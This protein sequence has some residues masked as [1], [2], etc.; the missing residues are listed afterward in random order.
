MK[1]FLKIVKLYRGKNLYLTIDSRIQDIVYKTLQGL[2]SG[3]IVSRVATGEI[4]AIYS[5]PSYDPNIFVGE[6]DKK[7]FEKYSK[8]KDKPF[9]NRVIQGGYPPSSTYK[10]VVSLTALDQRGIDFGT[11]YLCLGKIYIGSQ[12]FTC[13]GIHLTQHFDSAISNSCNV[14]FYKLGLKIGPKTISKYSENYFNLG[15]KTGIDLL[16]EL[17]GRIPNQKWK[18]E[19]TGNF[20]WDGDTANTSIG[21]GF[22][23]VTIAQ[24]HLITTAIANDGKGY[25]LHLLRKYQSPDTS[26]T[27]KP[28]KTATIDFPFNIRNIKYIQKAMRQVVING[29]ARRIN[30]PNLSIAGKTGTAQTSVGNKKSHSWFTAYAPFNSKDK[31][32]VIA[33]TVF[34]EH[35]GHGSTI[36]A[37]FASAILQGIFFNKDPILTVK[38]NLQPWVRQKAKYEDWLKIRN[39]KRLPNSYFKNK[40]DKKKT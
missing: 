6:L 18:I 33:V 14:F 4:L 35:G 34:V 27:F 26:E 24:T 12:R 32:D 40:K 10:L 9:F 5:Y 31:N 29:T 13:E 7:T 39:E 3:A 22:S 21:Q 36:A 38:E 8:N 25:K 11:N 23:I 17:K 37:P 28:S 1:L 20:W 16:F 30:L 19:Q 15:K 2:P